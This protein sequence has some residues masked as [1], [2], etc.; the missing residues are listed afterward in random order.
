MQ[1]G[2]LLQWHNPDLLK[3]PQHYVNDNYKLECLK[4]NKIPGTRI[5][6]FQDEYI[7]SQTDKV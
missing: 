2:K 3:T 6:H 4:A 5:S 7:I 1:L